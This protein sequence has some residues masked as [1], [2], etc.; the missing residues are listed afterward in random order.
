MHGFVDVRVLAHVLHLCFG[1]FVNNLAVTTNFEF[2]GH[3]E[4][5]IQLL[6]KVVFSAE[7][8]DQSWD[9]LLN[10]PEPLPGVALGVNAAPGERIERFD[11]SAI[12]VA[13]THEAG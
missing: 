11:P 4:E 8:L 12:T 13:A 1:H 3:T 6:N 5:G 10:R 2:I 7:K 9:V